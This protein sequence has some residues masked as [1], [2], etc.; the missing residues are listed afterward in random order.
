MSERRKILQESDQILAELE[1]RRLRRQQQNQLPKIMQLANQM[2]ADFKERRRQRLQQS[3]QQPSESDKAYAGFAGN[4][5]LVEQ[6]KAL[7]KGSRIIRIS[8]P[9]K[10]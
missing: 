1:Q 10:K 3:Q 2:V 6:L 7:P 4:Q 8:L 9:K 5:R